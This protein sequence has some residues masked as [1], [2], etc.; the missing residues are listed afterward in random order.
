MK[1]LLILSFMAVLAFIGCQKKKTPTHCYVCQRYELIYA[2][3]Y[4][5][6]NKPRT[7]VAIDTLCGRTDSWIKLYMEQQNRLDTIM[8]GTNEDTI[9]LNQR[10]SIC[11]IQ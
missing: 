1:K 3:V 5:Q 11:D 9:I 8:H 4:V 10:S 6:Y 2:P 7:L